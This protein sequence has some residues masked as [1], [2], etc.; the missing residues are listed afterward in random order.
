MK[1]LKRSPAENKPHRNYNKKRNNTKDPNMLNYNARWAQ[2]GHPS[3][4]NVSFKARN[5]Q[6]AIKKADRIAQEIDC[7]KT[8]RTIY[9]GSRCVENIT[10]GISKN[11]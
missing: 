6:A 4:G 11:D 9:E 2:A 7:T 8:P 10:S 3:R 5:D 1:S